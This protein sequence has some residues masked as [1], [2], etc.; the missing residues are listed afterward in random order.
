MHSLFVAV[1]DDLIMMSDFDDFIIFAIFRHEA[2]ELF[3]ENGWHS[4]SIVCSRAFQKCKKIQNPTRIEHT[5]GSK[6]RTINI[7]YN[8]SSG[9]LLLCVMSNNK[10][11]VPPMARAFDDC[12]IVC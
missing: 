11:H 8:H 7:T 10:M 12:S 1:F 4:P 2:D 9:W 3:N 5:P 6:K